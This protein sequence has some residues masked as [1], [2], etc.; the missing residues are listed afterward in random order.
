MS[1]GSTRLTT[2]R[3]AAARLSNSY[4]QVEANNLR[5]QAAGA[6][7]T[8]S[9][10]GEGGLVTEG[11]EGNPDTLVI[12]GTG[13]GGLID[14]GGLAGLSDDDHSSYLLASDATNRATF[15]TNWATLTDNSIADALHRHSELVAS[16]GSPDPALS[17]DAAGAVGIGIASPEAKL[18][19]DLVSDGEIA[20]ASGT[21][22]INFK[23]KTP[24]GGSRLHFDMLERR[25]SGGAGHDDTDLVLRRTVGSTKMGFL[26]LT[27]SGATSARGVAMGFN[28]TTHF[29]LDDSGDVGIG[30]TAPETL[31]ELT[32]TV[33][34]LT[35][36]NS[37]EEDGDTGRKSQI[38]FKGEQSGGEES[39][40][41]RIQ[42]SH[43][44][45]GDDQAG[46]LQFFTNSF[47]DGDS[48]TEKLR[49]S[50][51][52]SL[53]LR[54]GGELRFMDVGNSNFVG[55]EAPALIGNQIWILPDADGS[56]SDVLQ[57]DGSG[58]L[59][60]A[61]KA[62]GEIYCY[63]SS[64][65]ETITGTGIAN[66]VQISCFSVN[67]LSKLTTPAHASDHITVT[68]AG[69][70]KAMVSMSLES[71]GGT[72]YVLSAG[73]WTNNGTVQFQNVHMSRALSGGGSDTG[74]TSMN[75]LCT[76]AAN[77]TVE[78]WIWNETNTNNVIVDEITLSLIRID[79]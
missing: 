15:A 59:S 39:T 41:A 27:G 8:L 51:D 21:E 42:A 17:V 79:D 70:Y 14:H 30:E 53:Q 45:T 57:T 10:K 76:F 40:L 50:F 4:S 29:F 75:G 20:A 24:D 35:L 5:L 49:L 28:T 65:T 18:H 44:S 22:R 52:G 77:D 6:E 54:N 32:S 1:R 12:K 13:A 2:P 62:Y 71:T 64:S 3:I 58:N 38:S 68:K 11:T 72:P 60:W 31:L 61:T 36:H 34:Y 67:G 69:V 48:P 37:T 73:L 25:A 46:K 9:I 55:F 26:A 56:V 63:E 47:S 16:D 33:P 7:V 66:K 43:V 19:V 23:I 74:S 78:V